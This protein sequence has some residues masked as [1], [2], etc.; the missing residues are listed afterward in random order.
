M[1][2]SFTTPAGETGAQVSTKPRPR[3]AFPMRALLERVRV[4]GESL[5]AS[6][7]RSYLPSELRPR[8]SDLESTSSAPSTQAT[9]HGLP[10]GTWILTSTVPG[11]LPILLGPGR[12]DT[13]AVQTGADLSGCSPAASTM[14]HSRF[15]GVFGYTCAGRV[16]SMSQDAAACWEVQKAIESAASDDVRTALAWELRGHVFEALRCP[17]ANH[18]LQKII[19]CARPRMSQFI[20]DELTHYP[21]RIGQAARHK[22]GC[23]ILQRLLE[24]CEATQV[25]HLV[26]LLITDATALSVHA[27]GNYVMQHVLEHGSAEQRSRL[28]KVIEQ[29]VTA[30][31]LDSYGC[32]VV[33]AAMSH[34]GDECRLTLARAILKEPGLLVSLAH[35]RHGHIAVR[36]VL[37][38]LEGAEQESAMSQL[39]AQSQSL[40]TSRYGKGVVALLEPGA[41]A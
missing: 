18:V 11:N 28:A 30:I 34:A 38:A 5:E 32:A 3:M 25:H 35:A 6:P 17:H 9:P 37:Q 26:D 1:Q 29:N 12:R 22:Y 8:E 23:R 7:W 19:V 33:T 39:Q 41:R 16:W 27:Y 21:S 2:A 15:G 31:G 36:L 20:I 24:H 10:A 14:V 40:K 4:A 13:Q